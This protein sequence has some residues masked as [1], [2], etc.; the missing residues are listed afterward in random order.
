MKKTKIAYAKLCEKYFTTEDTKSDHTEHGIKHKLCG[1]KLKPCL[2]MHSPER[3]LKSCFCFD[4]RIK[5]EA[6][7]L[8]FFC[9]GHHLE[10][11]EKSYHFCLLVPFCQLLLDLP[12]FL[13][14]ML[15]LH[16]VFPPLHCEC[17]ECKFITLN[18]KSQKLK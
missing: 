14:E 17:Y 10:N 6:S 5:S 8:D 3:N 12:G 11:E 1:N 13:F 16:L 7:M 15:V 2:N 18:E 9:A 4:V